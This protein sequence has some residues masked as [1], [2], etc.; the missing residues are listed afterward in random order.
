MSRWMPMDAE[1]LIAGGQEMLDR[2]E[3]RRLDQ[4]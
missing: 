4:G 3:R 2:L 1:A